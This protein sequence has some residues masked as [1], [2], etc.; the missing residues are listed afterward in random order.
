MYRLHVDFVLG[1]MYRRNAA[2]HVHGAIV[3]VAGIRAFS[4]NLMLLKGASIVH[5][6]CVFILFKSLSFKI[7]PQD[8]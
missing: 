2:L 3:L 7:I 4:I 5:I 1:T 6:M 8:G